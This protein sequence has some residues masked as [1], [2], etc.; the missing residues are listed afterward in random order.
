MPLLHTRSARH[1]LR[2]PRVLR[3]SFPK[4]NSRV[5]STVRG[6]VI[7]G[8]LINR[9]TRTAS[10]LSVPSLLHIARSCLHGRCCRNCCHMRMSLGVF[11]LLFLFSGSRTAHAVKRPSTGLTLE[12]ATTR[13]ALLF[14][15][16]CVSSWNRQWH[17]IS[18]VNCVAIL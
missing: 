13:C 7:F 14:I 3:S 12:Q 16:S 15:S 17:N 18:A 6:H 1:A 8:S 2:W 4:S 10:D 11:S 9:A 5:Q